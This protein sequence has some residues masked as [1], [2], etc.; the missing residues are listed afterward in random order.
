MLAFNTE[1]LKLA[2]MGVTVVVATGDDGVAGRPE[3]CDTG[4]SSAIAAWVVC[5]QPSALFVLL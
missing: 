2:A 5:S 1:A 4:S 3:R